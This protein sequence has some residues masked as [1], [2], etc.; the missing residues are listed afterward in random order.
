LGGDLNS[1]NQANFEKYCDLCDVNQD[2]TI[3]YSD[4]FDT[5]VNLGNVA[6]W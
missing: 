2:G 3:T 6:D 4:L 5:K 1:S